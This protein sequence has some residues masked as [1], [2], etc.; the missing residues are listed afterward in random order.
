MINFEKNQIVMTRQFAKKC[1]D[2]RSPEYAH[3]QSVRRDY[4]EYEVITRQI[5]K[6]SSKKAYKGLTYDYMR[7]Y[8]ILHTTPEEETAALA[9]F[10]ELILI[11]KCQKQSLRYPTIKSWFL[12]KYPEVAKFGT[13][14]AEHEAQ[15]AAYCGFSFVNITGNSITPT[16]HNISD[17]FEAAVQL[18]SLYPPKIVL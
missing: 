7:D 5:K 6:N 1:T 13:V 12:D 9:E 17:F 10:D 2:T 16:P 15:Q 18:P 8:I 11:S 14:E 4:P 3:L